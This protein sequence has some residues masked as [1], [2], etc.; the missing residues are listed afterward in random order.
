MTSSGVMPFGSCGR[1]K[2]T[3]GQGISESTSKKHGLSMDMLNDLEG[4]HFYKVFQHQK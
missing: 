1:A 2:K 3:F 4:I